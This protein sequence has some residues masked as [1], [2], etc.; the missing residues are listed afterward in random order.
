MLTSINLESCL[1]R[2]PGRHDYLNRSQ[3][4]WRPAITLSPMCGAG[5]EEVAAKLADYLQPHAPPGCRWSIFD[6]NLMTKVLEEHGLS[7][8]LADS[9]PEAK[10]PLVT[11]I[12][13]KLRTG[14]PS[15]AKIVEHAVETIWRLAEGGYVIL[16]GRAANLVTAELKN[17][18]HVRL[19]GSLGKRAEN[20]RQARKLERRAA[21]SQVKAED[22]AKRLYVRDYFGK[23][24]D[25]PQH[26]HI[27]VNTDHISYE[28]TAQ[29]I[30]GAFL[31]WL[32]R[33]PAAKT[34]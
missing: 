22:E 4:E 1:A 11:E 26:Y 15:A 19:V 18:F 23:D 31:D 27:I 17:V 8:M 28:N 33:E 25:D 10:E 9:M 30:G 3:T 7:E 24:I 14:H 21:E 6:K 20:T 32:R 12:L 13:N 2:I 29:L 16:V 34:K 5:G